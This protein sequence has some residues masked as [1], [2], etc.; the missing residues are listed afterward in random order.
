MHA[1]PGALNAIPL[2]VSLRSEVWRS[3]Y[4]SLH[5]NQSFDPETLRLEKRKDVELEIRIQVSE[6]AGGVG[7]PAGFLCLPTRPS[8]VCRQ[9]LGREGEGEEL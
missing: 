2:S 7:L 3:R 6:L 8:L 5:P 1:C 9:R 4:E